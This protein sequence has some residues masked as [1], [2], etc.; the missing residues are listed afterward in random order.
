MKA[1][2]LL[3]EVRKM[4]KIAGLLNEDD[5]MES[6]I[7]EA[8]AKA[9]INLTAECSTVNENEQVET[10]NSAQSLLQ[11]LE[12]LVADFEGDPNVKPIFLYP[13]VD[14]FPGELIG[15]DLVEGDFKL[16][17]DMGDAGFI[18]IYQ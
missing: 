3:T 9:G 15:E 5:S 18:E 6:P 17:V 14:V 4:R 11:E 12:T 13:E 2:S 8:F 7:K 1:K 16:I 10:Y